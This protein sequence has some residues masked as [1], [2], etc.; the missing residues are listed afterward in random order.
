M[1]D[2]EN[3]LLSPSS[4]VW[5][6]LIEAVDPASL[7]VVIEQRMGGRLRDEHSAEDILQEALLHAWRGRTTCEWRGIRAFRSWLLTIIDHRLHDLSDRAATAKRSNG[8]AVLSF[9]ALD[10][11]HTTTSAGESLLP[12][13]ST[14][15]SRVAMYREQAAGMATALASLPDELREIVRLRLFEQ[16]PLEEIATRQNLGISAVRHRLRKGSELYVRAL[17][18]TIGSQQIP[19]NGATDSAGSASPSDAPPRRV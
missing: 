11:G 6:R 7:L 1:F 2:Q 19:K 13:V 14:T 9:T 18:S 5:Q 17:R 4:Q 10:Q 16:R 8:H 12:P 3:P 15:P